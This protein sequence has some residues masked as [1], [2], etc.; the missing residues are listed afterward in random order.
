LLEPPAIYKGLSEACEHPCVVRAQRQCRAVIPLGGYGGA[1]ETGCIACKHRRLRIVRI[2]SERV[3]KSERR[4]AVVLL[5]QV[6]SPQVE[7]GS[8]LR[9][10]QGRGAVE[11]DVRIL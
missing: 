8:R 6:Q 10:R 9:R 5:G 11:G 2:D 7:P 4:R 3:P 1:E